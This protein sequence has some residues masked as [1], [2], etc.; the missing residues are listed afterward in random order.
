MYSRLV[1]RNRKSDR[2]DDSHSGELIIMENA[3]ESLDS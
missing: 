1:R 2:R 3:V